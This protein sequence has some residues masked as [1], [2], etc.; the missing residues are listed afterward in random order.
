MMY[1]Y[2]ELNTCSLI[3]APSIRATCIGMQSEPV[4][5]LIICLD[6]HQPTAIESV[7]LNLK[8]DLSQ[9]K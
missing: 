5:V 1:T 8:P 6:K 2:V 3:T 9:F 4:N 7:K